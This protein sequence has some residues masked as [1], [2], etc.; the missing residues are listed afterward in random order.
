MFLFFFSSR[1]RHTR[2]I[3]DWSSDVCSSDLS[4]RTARKGRSAR[5]TPRGAGRRTAART[6]WSNSNKYGGPRNGPPNPPAF[7]A[8]RGTRGAPLY[9]AAHDV[10]SHVPHV[11]SHD[12]LEP[13][14]PAPRALSGSSPTSM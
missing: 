13:K 3:G 7:G 5:T 9:G 8:P 10:E 12:P 1:R 2:Y 4:S 14:P 11:Q 6:S